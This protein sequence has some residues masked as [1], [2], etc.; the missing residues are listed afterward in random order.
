MILLVGAGKRCDVFSLFLMLLCSSEKDP[1]KVGSVVLKG[2]GEVLPAD[3]VVLGVGVMCATNFLKS[4]G[5][6]L[7]RDGSIVVDAT[8]KSPDDSI[9]VVGDIAR[10][11]FHVSGEMV[12]VEHWSVAQNQARVAAH[13]IAKRV[14]G[15]SG[16]E[17]F[18]HIPY[19][20]SVQYGRSLRYCGHAHSFDVGLLLYSKVV[21][22]A[23]NTFGF[24]QDVIVRGDDLEDGFEAFYAKGEKILAVASL[25]KDPTVTR[26]S[27]LMRLGKMPTATEI[28]NG[29]DIASI[30]LGGWLIRTDESVTGL[31]R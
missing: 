28:R 1:S 12:R 24:I 8:M 9:Y 14:A 19:F 5:L 25:A 23:A 3:L 31:I 27:E 6:T 21:W 11:P 10:Y 15:E 2:T 18:E 22:K 26:S 17:K 7:E 30:P 29:K 4:S 16:D 20:W 13:N